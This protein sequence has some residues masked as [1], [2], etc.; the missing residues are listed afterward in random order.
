M[1]LELRQQLKLSQQLVMTP[2][3]QQAI[4]LLQMS[5]LDLVEA[6][7]Q[8][9]LEN[10]F[11][12][13]AAEQPTQDEKRQADGADDR[14]KGKDEDQVY[15]GESSRNAD[16]EDYLGDFASSPRD[17][18]Q[19]ELQEEE[20]LPA[21]TRYAEKPTLAG[22]LLW[23]LHLS[24]LEPDEVTAGECIIGNLSSSGYLQATC[25]EVAEMAHVSAE[26]VERVLARIQLFDPVGVA[27]RTPEECLLVQIKEKGLEG[28][29]VLVEMVAR[30]LADFESGRFRQLMKKFKLDEDD[31]KEYMAVIKS[32]DPMP[33]ASFGG[34]DPV[35]V[36]PDVYVRKMGGDFVILLNDDDLP[37]LTISETCEAGMHGTKQEREYCFEKKKAASWLIRSL[38][39]RS[40]TLYKVTESIVKHQRRFFEEGV[41]GLKPLILKEVAEDIG[42]HESTVSRITTNKYAA[43]P[44]GLFELKFFFNSAVEMTDGGQVGSESVKAFIK[45]IIA[46]E[47]PREPLSDEE[48]GAR[49]KDKLGVAI[50]RRTVAK[51]RGALDIPSSSKRRKVL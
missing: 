48:I 26:T 43:T 5:R 6:V 39:Q 46:G 36:S 38:E 18:Q 4:K 3:L 32:L 34:S 14:S 51:Y 23:Q 33:G 10:P 42:M 27:A 15:D 37:K 29:P 17:Y 11:L 19:R 31:L 49:L 24:S 12:E 25:G 35:Y 41:R 9:L 45:K 2:Q 44:H 28:D 40:R 21:E 1:S 16:W 13:E 50:A 8:E 47:D 20:D 30:H 7:H 22:H